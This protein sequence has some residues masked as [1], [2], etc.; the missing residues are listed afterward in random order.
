VIP[1]TEQHLT[2]STAAKAAP[3]TVNVILNRSKAMQLMHEHLARA[4]HEFHVEEMRHQEQARRLVRA[5]RAA[6]R[7]EKA[8]MRARRLQALAVIR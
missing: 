2:A 8:A 6:R 1:V 7:A 4:Q 3:T 5:R